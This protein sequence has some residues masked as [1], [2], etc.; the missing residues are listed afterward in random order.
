VTEKNNK[1]SATKPVYGPRLELGASR[2]H[3]EKRKMLVKKCDD[4]ER[5]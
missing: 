2:K 4:R 3:R 5:K 1:N